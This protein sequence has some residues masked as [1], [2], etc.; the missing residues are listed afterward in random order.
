M[1]QIQIL[2]KEVAN[3]IAAGE[4]VERPASVVKELVENSID[5]GSSKIEVKVKNGGKDLIQIIDN[6][7]G[8]A[9]DEVK[10][11][12]QR[13]ATSKISRAN[14]L[15]TL[16]TL[17][18]RGEALPS[19]AAVSKVEMISKTEDSL[20]GTRLQIVGGEVKARESCGCRKGTNI[21]VRDL[22]FN[23]PVR[24]KYLK[25]TST[26]I[27]HISDII[28]RLSLAYPKISFSLMHNDRQIVE[29]TGNGNLLDVIFNI[30][31]RDVAKEMIEVDYQDNYMQLTG[32]ISKPTITRS[33]R[34]HQ[35]Y[36]VNDRFIKSGLMSKAVKEAYHTLLTIDRYPIVVLKLKL[37]P[38]HVD[39][40][41]HPTKL[42][43]KFSRG[44]VVYE[45][46]KD[47]VSKAIKESD[48][49]PKLKLE[50]NDKQQKIN[51]KKKVKKE[52]FKQDE[53]NLKT[54]NTNNTKPNTGNVSSRDTKKERAEKIDK[55]FRVDQPQVE[56]NNKKSKI[57]E[58]ADN[59]NDK[60]NLV[61]LGQ[62]HQTYIVAQGQD[63]MYII[64]QHAAHERIIYDQLLSK[65]KKQ[66]IQIQELLVPLQLDLTYQEVQLLKER[67]ERLEGLGFN[68]EEF[69]ESSYL[70]RGVPIQLYNLDDKQLILDSIDN[71][72]AQE[73]TE[74]Y[75]LVEGFITMMA[76]K[77]AI[78]GGDKLS[79]TE[80]NHLLGQ[81]KEY[82]VTNCP[83]GRPVMMH[84]GKKELEKKFKRR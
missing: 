57:K 15:F 58:E 3:K 35:S 59:Y 84:L 65:F 12:F 11:A 32:Y 81:I 80:M 34:R 76:C 47:G 5:A 2:S 73:V 61:A 28:N 64:D 60:F 45:L 44:N 75:Q 23:T 29:T 39:V 30:Y 71:L 19:I 49:V 21:I 17:G 69:G 46:V 1:G 27:G 4:V 14:D 25:Q 18:F 38:V 26:E 51:Q 41:I 63:G 62:I 8:L 66:E 52:E 50:E 13:H 42:Q 20:S 33:S 40:N 77:T 74:N 36:F 6:G 16:R 54:S 79:T 70:V 83:H 78:K 55:L 9:E 53:L 68:L 10:L 37:N 56:N 31:G 22:F 48:L 7:V 24:Y 82:D 43:A 67:K 72:L